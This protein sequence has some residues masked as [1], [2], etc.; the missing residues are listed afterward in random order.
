V[1]EKQSIPES[2]GFQAR[3]RRFSDPESA[4]GVFQW[5]TY[6][7]RRETGETL[8]DRQ[9]KLVSFAAWRPVLGDLRKRAVQRN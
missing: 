6:V 1:H 2:F 5:N 7:D 3:W 4:G 9:S 8:L